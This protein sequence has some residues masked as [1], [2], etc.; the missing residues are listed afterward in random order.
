MNK[1][2]RNR[3]VLVIEDEPVQLDLLVDRL[4]VEFGEVEIDKVPTYSEADNYLQK[5]TYDLIIADLLEG[6]INRAETIRALAE[7]HPHSTVI[8]Y[9]VA[10]ES[11]P[12]EYCNNRQTFVVDKLKP[13]EDEMLGLIK[14]RLA[15]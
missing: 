3:R 10:P 13:I 14:S 7:G 1:S 9:T 2:A 11:F 6:Q 12:S 8:V 15:D 5:Q 4:T